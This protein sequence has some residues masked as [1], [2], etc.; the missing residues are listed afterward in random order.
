MRGPFGVAR[1]SV[2]YLGTLPSDLAASLLVPGP[3][4]LRESAGGRSA[5]PSSWVGCVD[6]RVDRVA[7]RGDDVDAISWT[8]QRADPPMGAVPEE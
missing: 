5:V 2:T 3:A 8:E 7:E 1:A 4:C 6:A